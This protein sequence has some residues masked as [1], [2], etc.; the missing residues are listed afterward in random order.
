MGK[1]EGEKASQLVSN[2]KYQVTRTPLEP[3]I[4]ELQG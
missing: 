3:I 4:E 2:H 1:I